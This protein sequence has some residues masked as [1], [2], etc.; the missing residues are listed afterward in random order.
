LHQQNVQYAEIIIAAGVVIWKG[1]EFAPIYDAIRAAAGDSPVRVRWILDA[2]R[3]F[4]V[5]HVMKVAE[6]A[7]ERVDRGVVAF[8]IGGSEERGP[9]EWFGDAFAFAREAG[10]HLVAHAGESMGPESVWAALELGA[11]RIGHGIAS[12]QDEALTRGAAISF[13]TVTSIGPV[14]FIV[15]AI[16]GLAFGE[17]AATAL[18]ATTTS[19]ERSTW[20]KSNSNCGW[21]QS[22]PHWRQWNHSMP[23]ISPS[24]TLPCAGHPRSPSRPSGV[25]IAAK[26]VRAR[27]LLCVFGRV[28]I[29]APHFRT[30][31]TAFVNSAATPSPSA[32]GQAGSS[33]REMTPHGLKKI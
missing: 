22:R 1:Q 24:L 7:A 5:E 4:G 25:S 29:R 20:S 10:L 14:L 6:L 3:Q 11:E 27:R 21:L 26:H 13:Y 19:A 33:N 28:E 15:V 30:G 2:V 8:G 32:R 16:A 9:A 23:P 17:E 12:V 31:I 18:A